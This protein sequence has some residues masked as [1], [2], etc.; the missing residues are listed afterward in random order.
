MLHS[1]PEKAS[2]L[3]PL[4]RLFFCGKETLDPTSE[5]GTQAKKTQKTGVARYILER[6][7]VAG[8]SGN[9]RSPTTFRLLAV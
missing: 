5:N 8:L 1:S 7:E 3:S 6:V 9:F 4:C 2:P